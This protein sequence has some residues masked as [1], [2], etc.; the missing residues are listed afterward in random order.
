MAPKC[1][2]IRSPLGQFRRE[3]RLGDR[4]SHWGHWGQNSR[5]VGWGA[6]KAVSLGLGEANLEG[7]EKYRKGGVL[8][9]SRRWELGNGGRGSLYHCMMVVTRF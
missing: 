3:G 5:V 7:R 1:R 9:L 8:G 6:E 4:S 2:P